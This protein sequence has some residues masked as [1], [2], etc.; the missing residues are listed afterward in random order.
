MCKHAS[1]ASERPSKPANRNPA[2]TRRLTEDARIG[3]LGGGGGLGP[4]VL[5]KKGRT[6]RALARQTAKTPPDKI[7]ANATER[8]S[9]PPLR[10]GAASKWARQAGGPSQAEVHRPPGQQCKQGRPSRTAVRRP[11]GQKRKQ[12]SRRGRSDDA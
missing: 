8:R 2:L 6:R 3:L 10:V 9:A 11:P 12:R 1:F 7:R 4:T 5:D